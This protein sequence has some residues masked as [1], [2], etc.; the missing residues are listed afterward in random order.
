MAKIVG[1]K[2][3]KCPRCGS[4]HTEVEG[5]ETFSF[6]VCLECGFDESLEYESGGEN[7][8]KKGGGG[9]SPYKR[10]GALRIQKR[11]TNSN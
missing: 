10:G 3:K 2:K 5:D 11:N 6:V 1:K 7:D 8:R 9:G 4:T